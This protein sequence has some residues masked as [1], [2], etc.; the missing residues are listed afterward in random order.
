MGITTV[1]GMPIHPVFAKPRDRDE[2]RAKYG[3]AAGR[4]MILLLAGGTGDGPVG[5]LFEALVKVERP[6]ELVVVAR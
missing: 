4:P 6:G 3:I 2:C 1:T 5:E